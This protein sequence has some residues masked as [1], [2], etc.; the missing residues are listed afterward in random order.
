LK[1]KSSDA[2]VG[3]GGGGGQDSK[4]KNT[5][6]GKNGGK[7]GGKRGGKKINLL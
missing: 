2:L 7:E 1:A 5:V 6:V 3:S 4:C